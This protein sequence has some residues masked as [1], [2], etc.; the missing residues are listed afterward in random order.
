[1]QRAE[2]PNQIDRVYPDHRAT[3]KSL[4]DSVQCDAIVR[5]V[6]C[7]YNNGAI[8]DIEIGVTR[9]EP[10][11]T[12]H[13]RAREWNRHDLERPR[14]RRCLEPAQIIDR[15]RVI[16]VRRILFVGKDD[17]FA[18]RKTRDVV[19]VTVRVV[20]DRAFAQPYS[21][22]YA[23]VLRESFL[24]VLGRHPGISHLYVRKEPLL[25]HQHHSPAV[26]LDSSPLQDQPLASVFAF[27]FRAR[28][29]RNAR[30]QPSDIGILTIVV[31]LGPRVEA[32]VDQLDFSVGAHDRGW[33]RVPQPD[34]I[35]GGYVQAVFVRLVH[36][37][38]GR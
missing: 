9:R 3:R 2:P 33:R 18:A 30:D 11:A 4:G 1:M 15:S 23:E 27:C 28:Q 13:H 34:A 32:P 5:V 6:E 20:T 7:R 21:I 16:L 14:F 36:H 35:V 38:M 25:G 24:V 31:V 22:G 19:D 29:S 17:R 10:F 8:G 12:H 26:D 37:A